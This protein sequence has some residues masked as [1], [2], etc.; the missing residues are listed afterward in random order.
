MK[1]Y[2]GKSVREVETAT[3]PIPNNMG[4]PKVMG[5]QPRELTRAEKE[6]FCRSMGKVY[7]MPAKEIWAMYW[8]YGK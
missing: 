1:H 4:M 8:P 2:E 6:A 3:G 7:A 5:G